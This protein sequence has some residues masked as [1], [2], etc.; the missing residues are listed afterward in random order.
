[1][2]E[3]T[4]KSY[5]SWSYALFQLCT[6]MELIAPKLKKSN[7]RLGAVAHTCNRSTLGGQGISAL[8]LRCPLL[9]CQSGFFFKHGVSLLLPRLECNGAISAHDNLCLLGSSNSSASASQVA[10]ITSTHHH[11]QPIFVFLVEI[12]FCHVGQAGLKL[13]T[14]GD[15]PTLASQS[16]GITGFSHHTRLLQSLKFHRLGQAQW[17]MPKFKTSLGNIARPHLC[18]KSFLKNWPGMQGEPGTSFFPERVKLLT[19][20]A[21]ER[22][23]CRCAREQLV[24]AAQQSKQCR[25]LLMREPLNKTPFHLPMAPRPVFFQLSIHA[26]QT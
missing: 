4:V 16:A 10:G 9:S 17:L 18:E 24:Q 23:P 11:A 1:M 2:E 13:L 15:P 6:G 3:V 8:G 19:L 20:K 26:P 21:E 5:Q 22:Q 12:G 25:E 14:S 7:S